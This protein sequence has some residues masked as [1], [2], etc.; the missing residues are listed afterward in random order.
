[1][2]SLPKL[3]LTIDGTIGYV[4]RGNWFQDVKHK[5]GD[6]AG[7]HTYQLLMLNAQYV[8]PPALCAGLVLWGMHS[9]PKLIWEGGSIQ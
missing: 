8:G 6:V 5:I 3:I 7:P 9:G 1:M 2:L 4:M